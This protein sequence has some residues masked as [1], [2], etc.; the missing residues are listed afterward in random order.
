MRMKRKEPYFPF[1]L[2]EFTIVDE[3]PPTIIDKLLIHHILPMVEIARNFDGY[4]TTNN[5]SGY[6]PA[7][8]E[9]RLGR[10]G[11]SEHCFHGK[12]AVDWTTSHLKMPEFLQLL[13]EFSPY[14]N[15]VYNT[16]LNYVHCDYSL[17]NGQR[18]LFKLT[19]SS[20]VILKS[21]NPNEG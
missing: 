8:V 13:W 20:N 21:V 7:E 17:G 11:K 2:K 5:N 19:S 15:M 1:R 4:I 9:K 14:T 3:I 18:I 16:A 6:R 10:N 12:G